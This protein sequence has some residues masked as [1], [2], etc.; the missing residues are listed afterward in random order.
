[1]DKWLWNA[2]L[3]LVAVGL[4]AM[5]ANGPAGPVGLACHRTSPPDGS[6]SAA[7]KVTVAPAAAVR[8]NGLSVTVGGPASNSA[9][10]WVSPAATATTFRLE[11]S[12]LAATATGSALSVVLRFPN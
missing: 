8:F 1:M 9:R 3:A 12:P 2:R 10:V 7:V 5:S 4:S 11:N 6:V